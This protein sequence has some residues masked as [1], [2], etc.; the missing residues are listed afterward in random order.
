LRGR[1]K[2]FIWN[3]SVLLMYTLMATNFPLRTA[4]AITHRFW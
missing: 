3:L 2:P 1:I 4:F